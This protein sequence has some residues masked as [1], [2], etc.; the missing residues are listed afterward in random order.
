MSD[1]VYKDRYCSLVYLCISVAHFVERYVLCGCID[2]KL[3][4]IVLW[5][6][7][8]FVLGILYRDGHRSVVNSC[9]RVGYFA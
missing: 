6:I 4:D 5:S 8:V 2:I 3:L 1:T 9:S 7:D